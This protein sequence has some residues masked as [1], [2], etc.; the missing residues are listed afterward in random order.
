MAGENRGNFESHLK[1]ASEAKHEIL[2]EDT[3]KPLP[4]CQVTPDKYHEDNGGMDSAQQQAHQTELWLFNKNKK[5]GEA[6]SS[7]DDFEPPSECCSVAQYQR[8]VAARMKQKQKPVDGSPAG[9]RTSNR[10]LNKEPMR[11]DGTN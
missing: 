3:V 11:C 10:L 8:D 9:K 5:D 4:M 6:A 1:S 2:F 7:D